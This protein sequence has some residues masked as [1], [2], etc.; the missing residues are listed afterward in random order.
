MQSIETWKKY[1]LHPSF[2]HRAGPMSACPRMPFGFWAEFKTT[3]DPL[4]NESSISYIQ[5]I[6]KTNEFN[7]FIIIIIIISSQEINH[8][9]LRDFRLTT[10]KDY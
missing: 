3:P 6:F 7:V 4:I 1:Y 9:L 8:H 2:G 5:A 10:R